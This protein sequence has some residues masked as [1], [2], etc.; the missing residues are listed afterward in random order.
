MPLTTEQRAALWEDDGSPRRGHIIV[1]ARPGTG[2]TSTVTEYCVSLVDSWSSA[3][4]P[5]QGMAMLSYTNVAK[6]ELEA[7]V[8]RTGRGHRLLS[9]PNFVGTIDSFV[10]QYLFLPFGAAYMGCDGRPSLVGEPHVMWQAT[11]SQKQNRPHDAFSP[12]FFDCYSVDQLGDP[13]R[14]DANP[15]KTSEQYSRSAPEPTPRNRKKILNTKKYIWSS[16]LALQSDANFIAYTTLRESET[17]TRALVRRFPVIV[18]DEAQDMTAVQHA[19]FDHLQA[20]GQQHIVLIGDEYQA[21]YEWNTARPQLFT[22]KRSNRDWLPKTIL[23]TFRCGPAI[24]GVLTAMADDDVTLEPAPSGRSVSYTEVVQ[25]RTFEK[26]VEQS[27]LVSAIDEMAA[28]L[29]TRTAHAGENEPKT[30]AI[31]SRGQSDVSLLQSYVTKS[32]PSTNDRIEW[33]D[34]LTKPYLRVVHHLASGNIFDAVRSYELVLTRAGTFESVSDMRVEMCKL[35]GTDQF[36][37]REALFSD[38]TKIDQ[39]WGVGDD[40]TIAQ[41]VKS[42]ETELVG[43]PNRRRWLIRQDCAI[44]QSIAKQSQDRTLSQIFVSGEDRVTFQ[45]A[46]FEGLNLVFS[47]VHGVKGE[48]YDGVIFHTRESTSS[49]GC[50]TPKRKWTE[51]L[52]HPLNACENKRIAYVAIS[53]AAQILYILTPEASKSVW[54]RLT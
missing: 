28:Y 21:I 16:G 50:A 15:R 54:E 8:C 6:D 35:W 17:L 23:Q 42:C 51:T 53:R 12:V 37:Y 19:I 13:I 18:V 44:F 14:I 10:N 4:S 3:Y 11:W 48:T 27:D 31:V 29:S 49:C 41:C 52:K 30:I 40:L 9:A 43:I 7:N 22:E 26:E 39:N 20:F 47:T 5:W 25:V 36:G 24:C 33:G 46:P 1:S 38:L 45:Y 2:K 34:A 32:R